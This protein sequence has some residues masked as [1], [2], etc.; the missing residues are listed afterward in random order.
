[1]LKFFKKMSAL[2]SVARIKE[3]L[4]DEIIELSLRNDSGL[5]RYAVGKDFRISTDFELE[6]E[7]LGLNDHESVKELRFLIESYKDLVEEMTEKYNEQQ[8]VVREQQKKNLPH[9]IK[10][11]E[12]ELAELKAM[13]K[14]ED[15]E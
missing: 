5:Y 4:K 7:H 10:M 6:L 13:M 9:R 3:H 12:E 15:N 8:K 2:F 14:D 11:L 1:M